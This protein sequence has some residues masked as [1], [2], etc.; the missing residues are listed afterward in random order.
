MALRDPRNKS[1]NSASRRTTSATRGRRS[2]QSSKYNP[3]PSS[4]QQRSGK[5]GTGSNKVT[6]GKGGK[7]TSPRLRQAL[8]GVKTKRT[9]A[10]APPKTKPVVKTNPTSSTP[11]GAQG[12]R[13]A[14]QQ[15]PSQKVNTRGLIGSRTKPKPTP[16]APPR[17]ATPRVSNVGPQTRQARAV[18]QANPGRAARAARTVSTGSRLAQLARTASNPYAAAATVIASDIKNR[19]VADGTLKGKPNVPTKPGNHKA[20]TK[21]TRKEGQKAT[22]NGKP[23]V[24]K[25]GKWA[26][27]PGS[28]A[29]NYNTRDADG[30]IRSRKRVGS[31]VG[32]K[33]VGTAEQA[34]DKAYA[35]AKKAGKTTFTH[36]GK[37]YSTK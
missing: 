11:R 29:G 30:T 18:Q 35:T 9:P 28:N 24:W 17:A 23:V 37:K 31:K 10:K 3:K 34:F 20:T 19:S 1:R 2:A 33:K 32:P 13:T 16:K 22:L 7:V 25:N 26:P 12:P 15:G 5:K 4:S 36:N 14:P 8:E 6:T 21:P 27:A